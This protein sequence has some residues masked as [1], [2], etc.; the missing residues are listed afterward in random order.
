MKTNTV[1]RIIEAAI[2]CDEER[3]LR[4][5]S[6]LYDDI[7][8]DANDFSKEEFLSI[9]HAYFHVDEKGWAVQDSLENKEL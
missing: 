8:K 1:F 7:N 2:D 4:Y 3:C 5:C 6:K 9:C